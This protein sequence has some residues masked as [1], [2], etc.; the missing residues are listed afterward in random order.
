MV[1]EIRALTFDDEPEIVELIKACVEN[2]DKFLPF[3]LLP[4]SKNYENFFKIEVFPI[5]FERDPAFGYIRGDKLIGIVLCS[6]KALKY[7]DMESRTAVGVIDMVHPKYRRQGISYLL[8]QSIA[9]DLKNRGIQKIILEFSQ[10]NIAS[11]GCADKICSDLG[12]KKQ[13]ISKKFTY[14]L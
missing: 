1:G 5:L 2:K 8:R 13:L 7:Y 3:N 4:T 10:N 6:T 12:I 9:K 14:D 11:L